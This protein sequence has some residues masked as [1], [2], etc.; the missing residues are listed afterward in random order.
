M[1]D[2]LEVTGD[3]ESALLSAGHVESELLLRRQREEFCSEATHFRNK[4]GVDAVV[5]DLEN[6][7]IL[8]GLHDFPANLGPAAAFGIV[9]SGER[10]DRNFIAEEIVRDFGTLVLVADESR[11][12][13]LLVGES[14][15]SGDG[16]SHRNEREKLCGEAKLAG[17]SYRGTGHGARSYGGDDT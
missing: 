7:P 9:D 3:D 15:E 5:D 11:P 6:P 2:Y 12:E 1:F 17:F 16:M 4:C 8:A 10:D 14:G 13:S